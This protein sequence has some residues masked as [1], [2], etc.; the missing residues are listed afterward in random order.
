MLQPR[1]LKHRKSFRPKVK[2][3]AT[4][5]TELAFESLENFFREKLERRIN[6]IGLASH[7]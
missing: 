3:R 6:K 1:K 5:K 2:G 7:L 4:Q